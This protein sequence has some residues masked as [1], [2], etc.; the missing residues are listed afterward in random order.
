MGQRIQNSYYGLLGVAPTA[1]ADEIKRA[2]R[3]LAKECHP[4]QNPA[5]AAAARFK[6][7]SEAYAV[8]SDIDRRRTYD[9]SY[10]VANRPPAYKALEPIRCSNCRRPTIQPRRVVHWSVVSFLVAT[11]R[12]PSEGIYCAG[13]AGRTGLRCTAIS[14]VLG[15][16]SVQGLFWTPLSILRNANGGRRPDDADAGLLWQNALAFRSQGELAIAHA[17]ARQVAA[18]GSEHASEAMQMLTQLRR[19]GVPQDAPPLPDAWKT[20]PAN[21]AAQAAMGL[22]V[23]LAVAALV[24]SAHA[25]ALNAAPAPLR[26]TETSAQ[27]AAIAPTC[28]RAPADGEVLQGHLD[29]SEFGHQLEINNVSGKPAIIKV[30]EAVSGI[31]QVAFF[32]GKGGKASVGPLPDGAYRIQYAFGPALAENCKSFTYIDSASE[33]PDPETFRKEHRGGRTI[34]QRLSYTLYPVPKDASGPEQI[35]PASFL[36]E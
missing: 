14:A 27:Q 1:T 5:P 15:W 22:F 16:W 35:D 12:N 30:R 36:A 7:I 18:S 9:V 25:P 34:A 31:T 8:L 2:F 32:V 6:V 4:D 21:V 17:L 24:Y 3:L 10:E 26:A 28:A 11:W 23:P 13:C 19:A 20:Q 29:Q 33:F